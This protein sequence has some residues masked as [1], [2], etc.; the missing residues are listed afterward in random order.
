MTRTILSILGCLLAMDGMAQKNG[1]YE[2]VFAAD[3]AFNAAPFSFASTSLDDL[4]VN[5]N[6]WSA[7]AG[8]DECGGK[9]GALPLV[10][11]DFRGTTSERSNV[12]HWKTTDEINTSHFEVERGID[13]RNFNRI[14]ISKSNNTSGEND[15]GFI[16]TQAPPGKSYYRLK[17]VD[18]DG[19][20]VYSN[21]VVLLQEH[22]A[23]WT[24]YP[25]PAGAFVTITMP[26]GK[27]LAQLY[28]SDGRLVTSRHF[29]IST[30]GGYKMNVQGLSAGSYTLALT[31]L[32]TAIRTTK[33][34]VI[35]Q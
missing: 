4:P 27:Y 32:A 18:I 34:L 30:P 26:N 5:R 16:D 24:V 14:G 6:I 29:T 17:M 19:Q 23:L 1:F 8:L 11:L 15:Y 31:D 25:N 9:C 12:L 20:Y 7:Y 13:A 33:T 35:A 10:L 28:G 22:S 3:T 2:V 21:I